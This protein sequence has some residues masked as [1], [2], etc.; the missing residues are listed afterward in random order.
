MI[1]DPFSGCAT[2]CVTAN[3]LYRQWA[4]I[5]ISQVAFDLVRRRIEERGGLFYN[6]TQRTDVPEREDLGDIP[7]YNCKANRERLYGMQ[8]G[9]CAGCGHYFLPR[10]RI[11]DHIIVRNVGG[12]DHLSN[13]QLLCSASNSTKG[14]RCMKYLMAQLSG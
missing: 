14:D 12:T 6:I 11:V 13:L 5:D 10:N 8:G 3:E 7:K 4:G 1:L 9:H 2:A